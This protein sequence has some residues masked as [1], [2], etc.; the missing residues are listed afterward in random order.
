MSLQNNGSFIPHGSSE[1]TP[2]NLQ[3]VVL[4]LPI[5]LTVMGAVLLAPIVPQLMLAFGDTP[6]AH[7]LVPMLLSLPA[8]CIALGAPFAGW[9]ADRVGRRKLLIGAMLV[10][11]FCGISPIFLDSYWAIFTSRLGVGLC[12]AVVITC[13]TTLIGDYFS[14]DQ[15]D[16]WLGSQAA[17]AS[18]TAMCL[19]PLAG[20]LGSVYGWRGPFAI[21]GLSLVMLVGVLLFTWDVCPELA[22]KG[23]RNTPVSKEQDQLPWLHMLKVCAYTLIGGIFFYILQFQMSSA[24][25][26]F[27][28]SNSAV[29][30][31]LLAFA[32][33]G[34]PAGAIFY[35]YAHHHFSI[36]NLIAIEFGILA[37]GFVSMTHAPSYQWFVVAGFL[38]QFGAGMLLPT[39][40]TWA[41]APLNFSVRGRGTGIWQSTFALG[42][43][44]TTLIFAWVVSMV[45]SENY[46]ASFQVFGVVALL[47]CVSS[48][49]LLPNIQAG[50]GNGLTHHTH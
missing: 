41:V 38:N 43:F 34:V 27:D 36:R 1:K 13:S 46:L 17:L 23:D 16:K 49:V 33:I 47:V 5:T 25:G 12:E 10:Y 6:N 42:Q 15:R 4:I 21:Y 2:G 40:L 26:S 45:G 3:G 7:Y 30:G 14:G 32:S 35:R 11:G 8:L 9:L 44:A 31:W 37:L 50:N 28:I 48:V 19:F 39:L 20:Y 22:E 29:T 24:L 18:L